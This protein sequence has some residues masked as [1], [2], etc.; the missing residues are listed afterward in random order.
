[1]QRDLSH[2]QID[3]NQSKADKKSMQKILTKDFHEQ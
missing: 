2:P 3:A 1:M